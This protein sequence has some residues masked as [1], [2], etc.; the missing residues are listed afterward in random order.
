[1][2]E[3]LRAK[4]EMKVSIHEDGASDAPVEVRLVT[5]ARELNARLLTSDDNLAKVARL[6]GISVLSLRELAAAMNPEL[7]VGD[8]LRLPL[9]KPGK[10]KNQAVGYL[11]DGAMIVVNNA[12]SHIGQ[13]VD[14]VVSGTLPTSAGRLIFAEIKPAA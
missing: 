14:V 6:R 8:E 2:M 7:S 13:T 11:P 9:T 3:K 1:M 10:D 4:P 12:A 5:L